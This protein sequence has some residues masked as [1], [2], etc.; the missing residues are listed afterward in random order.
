MNYSL[1]TLLAAGAA[2]GLTFGLIACHKNQP[3]ETKPEPEPMVEPGVPAQ[4]AGKVTVSGEPEVQNASFHPNR[5][6]EAVSDSLT[7]LGAC[8]DEHG[9]GSAYNA[10]VSVMVDATGAVTSA[11]SDTGNV[12]LDKCVGKVFKRIKF[13]EPRGDAPIK[14]TV[15]LK[16]TR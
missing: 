14:V 11:K 6:T 1:R 12:E 2:C 8:F 7:A 15:P 13:P 10:S 16:Y 9:G 5:A 4:A 3:V